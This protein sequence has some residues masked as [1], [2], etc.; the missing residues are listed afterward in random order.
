MILTAELESDTS[1]RNEMLPKTSGHLLQGHITNEGVRN[2]IRHAIGPYVDLITTV[3]KRKLRWHG[4]V[5]RSTGLAKMILGAR[6]KE[7]EGKADRKRDGIYRK[8][9]D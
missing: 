4:H 3:R 2:T 6:Y 5:T 1:Y 9:Q 7:G 8:G